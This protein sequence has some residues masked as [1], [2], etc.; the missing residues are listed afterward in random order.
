[1]TKLDIVKKITA[2]TGID[3]EAVFATIESF[4]TTVKGSLINNEEIFLRGFGTFAI[5]TR[6]ERVARNISKNTSVIIPEHKTVIFRPAKV[7]A[8]AM[9]ENK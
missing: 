9:K 4:M 7:L 1:M 2:E 3:E 8:E 6:K 5:K